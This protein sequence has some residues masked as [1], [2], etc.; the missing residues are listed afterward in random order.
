MRPFFD[1]LFQTQSRSVDQHATMVAEIDDAIAEASS[2][3]VVHGYDTPVIVM[4][5]KDD[6]WLRD[7]AEAVRRV[8][9]AEGSGARI[10]TL[11]AHEAYLDSPPGNTDTNVREPPINTRNLADLIPVNSV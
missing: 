5:D 4:F 2:H 6:A 7:Q 1:R 11:N 3:I 10:E 8:I 9:R